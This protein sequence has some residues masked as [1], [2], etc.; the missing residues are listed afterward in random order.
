[1]QEFVWQHWTI[2]RFI[3]DFRE[4]NWEYFFLHWWCYIF[5]SILRNKFWWVIYSNIDHCVLRKENIFYDIT[6]EVKEWHI[7]YSTIDLQ[8]E[9]RYIKHENF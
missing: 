6:G 4:K 8:S 9:L 2:M 7:K 3:K 5:S 1:M